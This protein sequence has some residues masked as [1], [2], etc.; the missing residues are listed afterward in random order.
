[1]EVLGLIPRTRT[2]A[3]VTLLFLCPLEGW[4]RVCGPGLNRELR[5]DASWVSWDRSCFF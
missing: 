5:E 2:E 4:E 1:M 3:A